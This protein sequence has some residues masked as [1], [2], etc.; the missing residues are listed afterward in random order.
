MH[1]HRFRDRS[2]LHAASVRG[3]EYDEEPLS[4]EA[5]RV[6]RRGLRKIRF[7]H[8]PSFMQMLDEAGLARLLMES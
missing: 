7:G 6:V 5:L 8:M 4:R 1:A 2:V 3:F